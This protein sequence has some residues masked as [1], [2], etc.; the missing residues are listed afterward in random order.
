MGR[1][2]GNRASC[3]A[4]GMEPSSASKALRTPGTVSPVHWDCGS[5]SPRKTGKGLL[6]KQMLQVLGTD[7]P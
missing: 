6:M 2:G 3:P 7:H 5:N 1:W 4:V